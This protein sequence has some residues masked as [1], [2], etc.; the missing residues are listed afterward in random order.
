MYALPSTRRS[1]PLATLCL[2][3]AACG[4]G[5]G[6]A[7]AADPDPVALTLSPAQAT[8][9][10]GTSTTFVATAW[11]GDGTSADVSS[12]VAWS[13]QDEAI[14]TVAAQGAQIGRV[15]ALSIG[16]TQVVALHASGVSGSAPLAVTP[17]VLVALA[18]TP[19][20]P[21]LAL[22]TAL[23][24]AAVGTF[25]DGSTQDLTDSLSWSSSAPQAV[26]LSGAAGDEGLCSA[27]GI[28]WS[29]V[30]ARHDA[31][32]ISGATQVTVTAAELVALAVTPTA[33]A[34]AL[35]TSLA[36]T[37]TGTFSDATT[38][39]LTAAVVWSSDDALVAAL[40]NV[41]GEEGTATALAE[42]LALVGALHVQSGL[43][44]STTLTVTPAV[45]TALDVSPGSASIA[46]GTSQAFA[47]T[48][49]FS[50]GSTQDLSSDVLWSSSAPSVATIESGG[51]QAGLA[52]GAALGT[53]TIA[54][55][56]LASGLQ[57]AADLDVTAAVLVAL[58]VA[59]ADLSI[60]LGTTQAFT[61]TGTFSDAT[62]QDLTDAVA[63]SS[64]DTGV[65]TLDNAPGSAGLATSLAPG[66]TTVTATHAASG[67]TGDTTLEVTPAVL[68][69]LA[70]APQD[71]SIALGTTQ[72][73]TATGT[74]S[75]GSTQALTDAVTWSSSDT[76]V[77]AIGNAVG[78]A[79]LATSLAPGT[80]TIGAVH[81][82]SGSADDTLLEVTAA[83]LVAIAIA[84]DDASIALG[85]TQ[86]FTATGTYSDATTQDLTQS[87]TWSSSDTGVATIGNA[88]GSQ[89]LATSVAVGPTT[90]AAL[91][92]PSGIGA[93]TPFAVSPA[94]LVALEVT[95]SN[96]LLAQGATRQYTATGTF[97][98]AS[99]QDLTTAVTWAS[100]SPA[101]ASIS[102]A[103]G[104]Q[105]LAAGVAD[106]IS[107]ITALHVSSAV[108]GATAVSVVSAITLRS[109]ASAGAAS[110]VLALELPTPAGT[111]AG[112]F[113][114][115]ALAVRPSSAAV[116]APAGWTLI[117]R[118]DNANSA[119]HSLLTYRRVA[120]AS[121]PAAHGFTLSA[122]TGS[123]GGMLAFLRVD[124]SSPIA[125]EGG[126]NT[127]A[128][129]SHAAPSI[130]P[131][132]ADTQ[133][134]T[135]HAFSSTATWTPPSGMGEA[136]DQG[137]GN[138]PTAT[139][140]S[141]VCS[142]APST[143]AGATGARTAVAANDADVGNTAALAL[144][145]AP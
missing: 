42:G 96:V 105:G 75:D 53:T 102:N 107:A 99:T 51:A 57:D 81:A 117:R 125:A 35:G 83:V 104:S 40:S 30:S 4:S 119:D 20:A 18:V 91:H 90:I 85:T 138:S 142:H 46:L 24:L 1:A 114:L 47:A 56:H 69:A 86:A 70:I 29:T 27:A 26:A 36:F 19:T 5:G 145:R 31:S 82:P 77:A 23:Q 55:L 123:A 122:S 127:P 109:A 93:S 116:T 118:V 6:G 113:L 130:V 28:G 133:L 134:V 129:L 79:G 58:E 110:G 59:P 66:T 80:S 7:P 49:T 62:T 124:A 76:G 128:S 103:P 15:S 2:L 88:G 11:F 106:G 33:P 22:G 9:A 17:A 73:F 115:A 21:A 108:M 135:V 34:L 71:P 54:A 64:S 89:G 65:A 44:G 131:A 32:G 87:V 16:A 52:T 50:D 39:D 8:L 68:V 12:D 45:L 132:T 41:A 143:S 100:S 98:D 14:A 60:A 139:G 72:A 13:V 101:V 84:P 61:A 121:E 78:N 10:L 137:S 63:W 141:L 25:S 111:V 112:D 92:A 43:S 97:S 95:P 136:F 37:A 140:I 38:Q 126:Q 74:Y 120:D 67:V 3:A 48:G 94:V 144:R